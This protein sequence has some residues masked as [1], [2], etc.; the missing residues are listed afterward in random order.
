MAEAKAELTYRYKKAREPIRSCQTAMREGWKNELRDG[1]ILE[2]LQDAREERA[3]TER[4]FL[5]RWGPVDGMRTQT[6]DEVKTR[7]PCTYVKLPCSGGYQVP[8]ALYVL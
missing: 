4:N 6:C 5:R 2:R 8:G 3:E 1:D 7:V